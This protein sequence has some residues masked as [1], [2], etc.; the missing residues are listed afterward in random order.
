MAPVQSGSPGPKLYRDAF[1]PYGGQ[2]QKPAIDR[3]YSSLGS[4]FVSAILA[5]LGL[6]SQ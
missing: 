4:E 5:G 2:G 3:P 1:S 6:G